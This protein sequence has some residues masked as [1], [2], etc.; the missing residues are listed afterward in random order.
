MDKRLGQS[1]I[2]KALLQP[3]DLDKALEL[4]PGYALANLGRA[5]V[6]GSRG[7]F[8]KARPAVEAAI[9]KDPRLAEAY[10]LRGFLFQREGNLEKAEED[11]ET[12]IRF[13]P[14]HFTAWAC[15][16]TMRDMRGEVGPAMTDFKEALR[17][18][19]PSW[20]DRP[21]VE[22]RLATLRAR[23]GSRRP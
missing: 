14:R 19:P 15:R 20:P 3:S 17:L 1:L 23:G 10:W 18:A 22:A 2:A 7:E 11:Y 4:Q 16:G 12:T 5:R 21:R 13:D 9:Q 8:D 6:F